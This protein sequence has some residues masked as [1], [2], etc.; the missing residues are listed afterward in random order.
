[1]DGNGNFFYPLRGKPWPADWHQGSLHERS[2][3][4]PRLWEPYNSTMVTL[5]NVT[6]R[7]SPDWTI[8]PLG[9]HHVY[10]ANVT[11]RN[12]PTVGWT[13]GF[14]PDLSKDVLFEHGDIEVGDDAIAVKSGG[15]DIISKEDYLALMSLRS[16]L[17]TAQKT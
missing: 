11:V 16:C 17:G 4:H 1:M 3:T 10:I 9:C 7:N 13:D 8:H 15:C 14:D 12:P 6:L 5:F 2:A